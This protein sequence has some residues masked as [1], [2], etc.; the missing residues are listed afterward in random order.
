M[1]RHRAA[2][3]KHVAM[4]SY[5]QIEMEWEK[6]LLIIRKATKQNFVHIFA[7]HIINSTGNLLG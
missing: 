5:Y 6:P 1:E 7:G 4:K 3:S 2:F